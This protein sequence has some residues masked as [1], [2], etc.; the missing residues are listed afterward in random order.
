MDNMLEFK[1]IIL[2]TF[3]DLIVRH[4]FTV[5]ASRSSIC[6]T[7]PYCKIK[8][9]IDYYVI[10]IVFTKPNSNREY[11]YK[12]MMHVLLG[13]KWDVPNYNDGW[14]YI[15][16]QI[17]YGKEIIMNHFENVLSG[18][19]TWTRQYTSFENK[20]RKFLILVR[21]LAMDDPIKIKYL[22]EDQSWRKDLEERIE[23]QKSN[24]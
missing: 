22:N 5:R 18:D 20:E 19:F 7:N 1:D 4:N 23:N 15:P 8:F 16:H 9:Y 2:N 14:G 10:D 12:T 3:E 13:K 11:S 6:L 17:K 21:N 24:L